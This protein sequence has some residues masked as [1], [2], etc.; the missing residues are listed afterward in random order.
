MWIKR[1]ISRFVETNHDVIQVLRGP[2]QCGKTSLALHLDSDFVE[3]SLDDP[4]LR[5]LA[6]SDP[7]QFLSRFG[8]KK[9]FIDEAQYAPGLFPLLKQRADQYKR[10]Q[11]KVL[12]TQIRITG[13]NQILMDQQVKESLAGR[14]S[15]F[16]M[17]TLSVA[18]IRNQFPIPIC[19]IFCSKEAGQSFMFIRI[20]RR[21]NT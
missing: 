10:T 19:E 14:A 1:D 8:K 20:N 6:Q 3:V 5:S 16:D 7:V 9:I 21:P 4:H 12:E 13:S 11:K 18:E 15:F 2:R 17:N